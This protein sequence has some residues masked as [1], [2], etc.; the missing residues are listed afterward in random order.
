MRFV[1]AAVALPFAS[2]LVQA[3]ESE[4]RP[5]A[6]PHHYG[7]VH[8][9]LPSLLERHPELTMERLRTQKADF[10]DQL[11][12]FFGENHLARDVP[13]LTSEGV[14]FEELETEDGNLFI[15][16]WPTPERATEARYSAILVQGEKPLRYFTLEK[17]FTADE[18]PE[19]YMLCEWQERNHLNYGP[20][21]ARTPEELAT[22]IKELVTEG[23]EPAASTDLSGKAGE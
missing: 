12:T 2:L 15:L 19:F 18:A 10:L 5:T 13:K 16:G 9:Y 22:A 23:T 4:P 8:R 21:K 7:I 11:W 1:L 3:Q 20:T 6:R 17:T 14:T